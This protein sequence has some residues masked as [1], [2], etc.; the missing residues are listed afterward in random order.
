MTEASQTTPRDEATDERF[1]L[2]TRGQEA[3]VKAHGRVRNVESGETLVEPH[4]QINNFFTVISGELSL[5]KVAD[6]H[7]E[8]VATLGPGAFTGEINVLSGRPG[9]A[10]IRVSEAGELIEIDREQMLSM[11][12]TDSELS[13]IFLHAFILRRLALIEQGVGDFVLIGSTHSLD[14][15]RIKEFLTRNSHPFTYVDL[16]RDRDVEE[17]LEH[18]HVAISELPV[19]I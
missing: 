15:L 6:N 1:P 10:R 8:V 5:L 12:Q 13:D 14:T 4:E 2:L 18:F 3:R 7:E 17:M 9:L 19:T 16:D 11:V